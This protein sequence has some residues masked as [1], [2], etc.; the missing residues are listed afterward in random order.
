MAHTATPRHG[1]YVGETD[2]L[3]EA[4]VVPLDPSRISWD[5]GSG[6][7]RTNDLTWDQI[8]A[9]LDSGGPGP[10][11]ANVLKGRHFVLVVGYDEVDGGDT[12]YVN[13]P[14]FARESYSYSRD[15]VGWRLYRMREAHATPPP[16]TQP[17]TEVAQSARSR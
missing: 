4:A 1:G 11:I 6:M 7:H 10:L 13:D 12:L 8:V 15:V 5:E 16:M 2:D 9:M 3:E 17:L 14:G